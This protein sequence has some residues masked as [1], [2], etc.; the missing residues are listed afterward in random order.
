MATVFRKS[1]RDHG[2]RWLFRPED[3]TA[4]GA[5]KYR[6]DMDRGPTGYLKIGFWIAISILMGLAVGQL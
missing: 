5:V 2:W 1:N 3:T 6:M 4:T